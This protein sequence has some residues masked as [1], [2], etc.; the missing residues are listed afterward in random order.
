PPRSWRRSLR[1]GDRT[2]NFAPATRDLF[3]RARR[4]AVSLR[5]L[6]RVSTRCVRSPRWPARRY[7]AR[8]AAQA[9]EGTA[10]AGSGPGVD[11]PAVADSPACAP[12][13]AVAPLLGGF[14]VAATPV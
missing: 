13:F 3:D 2:K 7:F 5:P 4:G 9:T 8:R 12:A 14:S 6:S 11:A 10:I 1:A